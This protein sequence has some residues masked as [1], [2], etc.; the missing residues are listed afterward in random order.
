MNVVG[1]L[2]QLKAEPH[3]P[4]TWTKVHDR[5]ERDPLLVSDPIRAFLTLSFST[6]GRAYKT[7][8]R[9]LGVLAWGALASLDML[10]HVWRAVRGARS[11]PL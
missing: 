11:G 8:F 7:T 4:Q 10:A 5:L 3:L 2:D 1:A 6:L 9:L